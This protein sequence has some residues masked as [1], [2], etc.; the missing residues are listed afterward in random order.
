M[1]STT[2]DTVKLKKSEYKAIQE[3]LIALMHKITENSEDKIVSVENLSL[4]LLQNQLQ[5]FDS[6]KDMQ[7]YE[8]ISKAIIKKMATKDKIFLL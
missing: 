8:R 6:V 1:T 2:K 7:H 5:S 3:E 4:Q